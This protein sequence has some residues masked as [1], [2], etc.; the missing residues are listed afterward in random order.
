ML[1]FSLHF[2][3]FF[4]HRHSVHDFYVVSAL[5][6]NNQDSNRLQVNE[7]VL[8]LIH[9][10]LNFKSH[11]TAIIKPA[12]YQPKNI[13]KLRGRTICQQMILKNVSAPFQY[14]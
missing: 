4:P 1:W 6:L 11:M 10:E 3:I 13:A 7:C 9:S 8:I 5:A 12:S 2:I 14:M